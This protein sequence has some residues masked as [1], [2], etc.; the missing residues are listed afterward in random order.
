MLKKYWLKQGKLV[1]EGE[2][3]APV[4][5]YVDPTDAERRQLVDEF[6]LD[7]HTLV[8]ALDPDEL[9]RLEFE[10]DHVALIYKRPSSYQEEGRFMFRVASTGLFLF[11]ERLVLVQAKEPPSF[12]GKMFSRI[13]SLRSLVLRLIS[14]AV[15]HYWEHLKVIN[16]A[17]DELEAKVN[18][19]LENRYLIYMFVLQ[20]SLVYYQSSI[21]SNSGLIEKL[22][23]NAVRLEFGADGP[24]L[25]E[26]LSIENAQCY[27]QAEIYSSILAGLMDA[28]ASIVSNNLNVLMK[29]LNMVTIAIM[30]PTFVVSAFSMNVPVPMSQYPWS[31]WLILG[32]AAISAAGWIVLW[33]RV[34]WL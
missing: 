27:K 17:T 3:D 15:S 11:K 1:D 18:A 31:F 29:N 28:R 33:K 24:E 7:E 19:S 23:N 22:R 20:K 13:T 2:A 26:D 34:R 8:S 14:R 4:W 6:G 25:L 5:V 30:V 9:A 10:P 21:S 16:V 12:D 32:M